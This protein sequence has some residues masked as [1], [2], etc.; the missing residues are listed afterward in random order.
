M[1][2]LRVVVT[3]SLRFKSHQAAEALVQDPL[4]ELFGGISEP[5]QIF[6]GQ[7]DAPHGRVFL[8]VPQDVR[9]LKGDAAAF[10]VFLGALFRVSEDVKA[11]EPHG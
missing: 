5:L 7:I 6:S 8:D 3:R 10:R 11:D 4:L 1:T 9:E 2:R